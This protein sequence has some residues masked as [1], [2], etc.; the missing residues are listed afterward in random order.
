MHTSGKFANGAAAGAF[1]HLFIAEGN[2][3]KNLEWDLEND[4]I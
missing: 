4:G 1:V 3:I 2:K